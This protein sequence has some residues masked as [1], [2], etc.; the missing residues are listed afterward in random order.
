MLPAETQQALLD[1]AGGNPLYA[2][3]FVRLLA[4]RG[5]LSRE[6]GR[7][8]DS[9]QALIAARLDTLPPER[10]SLLQDAAVIGKVFWAGAVAEMGGR[11]RGEVEQALHELVRK[12]LVRPARTSLDGRARRSTASGTCS[13]ATSPTAQIP[14]AGRA[15]RHRAAAAWI[16]RRPASA[17]TTSPTCSPTTTCSALELA[18][19]AGQAEEAGELEERAP[20]P[21]AR[22]RASAP[23]RRHARDLGVGLGS[24]LGFDVQGVPMAFVVTSVRDIEWRSF[25]PNFFLVAEPGYLEDAPQFRIGAHARRRRPRAGA[26]GCPRR[27]LPERDGGPRAQHDRARSAL[28]AQ[29]ALGVRLL[30]GFAVL[31]G[32]VILIG[33]AAATQLRRAREAALLKTLGV[34]RARVAAMFALEYALRGASRVRSARPA[35]TRSR[36]GSRARCSRCRSCPRSGCASLPSLGT[37]LLS[38]LGGLLAS[39]RALLVPPLAVL[40]AEH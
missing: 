7:C 9:V 14:R 8:P 25:A 13:S 24:T 12:E 40:R 6:A 10:K 33:A 16:E 35:P 22:G 28:I 32:L 27:E 31:T 36:S 20:L 30:G 11:D 26:A 19:A 2:E 15:D 39:T 18:R 23:L 17:S 37:T 21:R 1:R 29:V 34:T 4:D 3:E 38:V 5:E